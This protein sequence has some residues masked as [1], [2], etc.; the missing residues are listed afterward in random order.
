[1]T[2]KT[3][4]SG[5]SD[6]LLAGD[7]IRVY[8][9]MDEA[10]D[11]PELQFV[12]VLSVTDSRGINI[13]NTKEPDEDEEKL[14]SATITVLASP[15]QAKI[16]TA[17]EN[18]G[19]AHVALISRGNDTLAEELLSVQDQTLME[20]YHPEELETQGPAEAGEQAETEPEDTETVPTEE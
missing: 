15:E 5:L 13:D 10:R 18:D 14:Q 4:A 8:H 11:I 9:F 17:M 20:L 3:L 7:I 2:V 12:K 6:K 16:I 19:V 1:M